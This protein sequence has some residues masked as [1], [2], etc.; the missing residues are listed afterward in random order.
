MS[1]KLGL[2]GRDRARSRLTMHCGCRARAGETPRSCLCSQLGI[3]LGL[4][5]VHLLRTPA[6][7]TCRS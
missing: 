6:G 5:A 3:N 1:S 2:G 7:K 4:D